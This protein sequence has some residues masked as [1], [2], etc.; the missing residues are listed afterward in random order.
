LIFIITILSVVLSANTLPDSNLYY[1]LNNS[2][3]EAENSF[4]QRTIPT[5]KYALYSLVVP[6][7]GQ[8]G[9]AKSI[10]DRDI[11][12]K[13]FKKLKG[14]SLLFLTLDVVSW[15]FNLYNKDK[16][17]NEIS[18]Y[19]K[20]A[21]NNWSFA[22]WIAGYDQFQ[23]SDYSYLWEENSDD[24]QDT[25]MEIGES[26]H[27]VQFRYGESG[28]IIRTTDS[29]FQDELLEQLIDAVNSEE[30]IYSGDYSIEIIKD[31][32]FY[33]NIGKYNEF[34]SGW[35]DGD[36][37]HIEVSTTDH[38]Y[39]TPR[40]P[41]KTSYLKS[42]NRAETFS[43]YAEVALLCVYFNHFISMIDAFIL[44]HKFNGNLM[45]SS[46]TVLSKETFSRPIGINLNL[47]I[48]I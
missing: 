34:F 46:S 23:G 26:S 35:V 42:Y 9:L 24:D 4:D 21:D 39:H 32:H 2:L 5:L 20:Y 43:D 1:Q 48:N 8:Y 25:W 41:T 45:L 22:D 10:T 40:S 7:A 33:E 31:Q 6:G 18:S 27:Y 12:E 15:G 17:N 3:T 47:S 38:G 29:H 44:T 28:Q 19:R 16:Y 37:S 13:N 36:L 30:D 14:K 11:K